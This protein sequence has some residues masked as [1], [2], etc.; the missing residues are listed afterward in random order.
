MPP[1]F[2]QLR[3]VI[4]R[5]WRRD[6]SCNDEQKTFQEAPAKEIVGGRPGMPNFG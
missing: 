1:A 2:D 4:D 5:P 6:I 3:G